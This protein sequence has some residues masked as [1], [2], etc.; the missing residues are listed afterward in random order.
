VEQERSTVVK[1]R[2][3][4]KG[5]VYKFHLADG[6]EQIFTVRLHPETLAIA[7]APP[8]EPPEWTRLDFQRCQNCPLDPRVHAHCPI[9]VRVTHLIDAFK[10]SRSYEEATVTVET[11]LRTYT[12]RTSLQRGLS[13]MLGIYMVASGCPVMNKLRPMVAT[14]LP[15][16]SVFETTYRTIS[17]YV[18]AQFLRNAWGEEPDFELRDLPALLEA[19]AKVD[20]GFCGRLSALGIEDASLNAIAILSIL[21]E[22]LTYTLSRKNLEPWEKIFR[23]HYG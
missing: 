2:P 4:E 13:S 16:A 7:D 23:E 22:N 17:M 8:E 21:G 18:M 11:D 3:S 12:S 5:I 10:E 6:R 15:F 14:H 20:E 1:R 9:A 19:I